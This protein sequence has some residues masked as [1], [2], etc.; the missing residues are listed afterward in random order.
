M[1]TSLKEK[2]TKEKVLFTKETGEDKHVSVI[3]TVV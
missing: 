1:Q 2:Y 3:Y